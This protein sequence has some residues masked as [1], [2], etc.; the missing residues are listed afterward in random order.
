LTQSAL[1]S[2][3]LSAANAPNASA[4][5]NTVETKATRIIFTRISIV[6]PESEKISANQ[7]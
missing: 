7:F 6:P 4:K 5:V 1:V 3:G 2:I